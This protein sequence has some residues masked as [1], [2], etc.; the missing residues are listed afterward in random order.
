MDVRISKTR[1]DQVVATGHRRVNVTLKA[2]YEH[3]MKFTFD[4]VD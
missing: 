2:C 3:I 4:F 1:T